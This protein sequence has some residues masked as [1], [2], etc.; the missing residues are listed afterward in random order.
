MKFFKF[1]LLMQ[2]RNTILEMMFRNN[3]NG[4]S[5]DFY[6]VNN[7]S[8]YLFKIISFEFNN[9]NAIS[10]NKMIYLVFKSISL[11]RFYIFYM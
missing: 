9:L 1:D 7:I 11:L 5:I 10:K 6:F 3:L 2:F 8:K 4:I